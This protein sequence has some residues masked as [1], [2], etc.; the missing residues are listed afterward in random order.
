MNIKTLSHTA[1]DPPQR[2]KSDPKAL[3]AAYPVAAAYIKAENWSRA[4]N[5][6]KAAAGDKA[7]ESILQGADPAEALAAMER[8]WSAYCDAHVWD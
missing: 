4:A 2:S 7:M 5:A 8:E 1:Q 6:A 3:M